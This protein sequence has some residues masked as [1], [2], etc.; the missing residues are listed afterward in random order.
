MLDMANSLQQIPSGCYGGWGSKCQSMDHLISAG[1]ASEATKSNWPTHDTLGA[2]LDFIVLDRTPPTLHKHN[3]AYFFTSSTEI[4]FTCTLAS[5]LLL[6]AKARKNIGLIVLQAYAN[7]ARSFPEEDRAPPISLKKGPH[8]MCTTTGCSLLY[9]LLSPTAIGLKS[10]S[11]ASTHT[12][13]DD[14][15]LQLA[16]QGEDCP[17]QAVGVPQPLGHDA[18]GGDV[19]EV[20]ARVLGQALHDINTGVEEVEA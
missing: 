13:E 17:H 15:G 9:F 5:S 10:R 6:Q 14:T 4:F 12:Y 8:D 16:G 1:I 11:F 3:R 2:S 18:A 7:K 20:T 19:E